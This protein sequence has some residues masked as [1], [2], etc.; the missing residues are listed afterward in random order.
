[1]TVRLVCWTSLVGGVAAINYAAYGTTTGT[2]NEI[3]EWSTFVDLLIFYG[4]VL[5]LVSLIALDRFDLF[6]VRRPSGNAV[7]LSVAI[8]IAIFVWEF[9]VTWLPFEDPGREQGLTPHHFQSAHAAEFAAN[10]ALFVLFAPLVEELTFRGVGQSLWRARF[11]P[12][13]GILVT[14]VLFGL[15]HGLLYAL[16]VLIPFGIALAYLRERTNSV[17]PGIAVHAFF[18]AAAIAFSLA[19]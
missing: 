4:L 5:F 11:G 12:V 2:G 1:V 10:T 8:V 13:A 6:A 18:N 17:V 7:A 14:G 15:W 16:I 9:I 19:T 3:Y